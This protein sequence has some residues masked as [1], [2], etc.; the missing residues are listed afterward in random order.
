VKHTTVLLAACV[1]ALSFP[2]AAL[3]LDRPVPFGGA[4]VPGA[5]AQTASP[6]ARAV[7]GGRASLAEEPAGA[8]ISGS[9]RE[10]YGGAA[11]GML[12]T[13]WVPNGAGGWLK[14]STTTDPDG[15]YAFSGV[16]AASGTGELW[17]ARE[18][19]AATWELG[20]YGMTWAGGS[21]M[22]VDW[23]PGRVP[24]SGL[25]GGPW[26]QWKH[27]YVYAWTAPA[28]GNGTCSSYSRITSTFDPYN[29]DWSGT[30]DVL[31]G[32]GDGAVVY[33]WMNQGIEVPFAGA[34][35]PG[36]MSPTTISADQ[37]AASRLRTMLSLW[38]SGKPGKRVVLNLAS[39]PKGSVWQLK[40]RSDYPPSGAW[41]NLTRFTANESEVNRTI[42]VPRTA[43]P[44]Y[45][46][47]LAAERVDGLG[48]LRLLYPFQVCTLKASRA[49]ISRGTQIRV[50]GVVPVKGRWGTQAGTP[51]AVTLFR[52]PNYQGQ[53]RSWNPAG[54][55]WKAVATMRTDGHGRFRSPLFKLSRTSSLIVRYPGDAWYW[56]AYTTPVTVV[57]K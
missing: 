24:V 53:P 16:P 1:A 4:G 5:P 21:T 10:Y 54:Q 19:D 12:V 18:P 31:P 28:D 47:W 38:D 55:G 2:V 20:R 14:G 43:K 39:L 51:K 45:I 8:S 17:L 27:A 26:P 32:T 46:C 13:W 56:R 3:A 30:L 22:V 9:V 34:V 15:A 48:A 35:E 11:S 40:A 42:T 29:D 25:R 44:G 36:L 37:A 41:T 52:A 49:S 33:F 57:V 6:D 23:Q 50:S 7:A